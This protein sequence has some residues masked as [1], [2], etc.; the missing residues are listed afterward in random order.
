MV[1]IGDVEGKDIVLI[2]EILLIPAAPWQKQQ[3]F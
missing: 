2:D 3:L 1:L